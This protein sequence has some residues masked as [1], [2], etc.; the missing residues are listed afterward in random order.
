MFA[1][2]RGAI[3]DQATHC[4]MGDMS[5]ME[6]TH[7]DQMLQNQAGHQMNHEQVIAIDQQSCCCDGDCA[8]NCDMGMTVSLILQSSA[9]TPVIKNVSESIRISTDIIVRVLTPPSRPPAILYS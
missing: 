9:Y 5:A 3:A 8:S 4:Q 6:M 2:L 1:P 7:H